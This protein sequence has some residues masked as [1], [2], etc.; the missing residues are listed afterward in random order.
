[1]AAGQNLTIGS[2]QGNDITIEH[3]SV[4]RQH[5]E[6]RVN[7]DGS[8]DVFD[9]G[10]PAGTFVFHK[11][12]WTRFGHATV[13]GDER[14][15]LGTYETSAGALF[16]LAAEGA[17]GRPPRSPQEPADTGPENVH[18]ENVH[19]VTTRRGGGDRR[20][21]GEGEAEAETQGRT[22]Q[23]TEREG[24]GATKKIA[25]IANKKTQT[26]RLPA[27]HAGSGA[28]LGPAPRVTLS[29]ATTGSGAATGANSQASPAAP[30]TP[31]PGAPKS[32]L[33]TY[34]LWF[35]LGFYGAHRFYLG[36]VRIATAQAGLL[37]VGLLPVVVFAGALFKETL[38]SIFALLGVAVLTCLVIW[39]IVDAFLIPGLVA[40]RGDKSGPGE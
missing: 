14:L 13:A 40:G 26:V 16:E 28:K 7:E 27:G 19:E 35:F 24:Q 32:L 18:G 38:A 11:A 5:A 29:G 10:A 22:G 36:S 3:A 25:R 9:L 39:W 12:K 34:L 1:M 30:G 33:V 2:G 21:A 8:F 31:A 4:S 37:L 23:P 17:A 6:L 20:P 15:R